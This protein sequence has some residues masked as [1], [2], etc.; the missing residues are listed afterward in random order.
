MAITKNSLILICGGHMTPAFAVIEELN[1]RGFKNIH[2]AGSLGY[3]TASVQISPEY[4]YCLEN[5][6]PFHIIHAGS[7]Q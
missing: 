6:I 1:K 7:R 5:Q 2:W 3:Q 4:R